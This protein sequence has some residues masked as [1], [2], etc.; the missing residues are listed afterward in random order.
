MCQRG[1]WKETKMLTFIA[2]SIKYTGV[3]F[4]KTEAGCLKI[5]SQYLYLTNRER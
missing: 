4:I 2:Y 3:G 1:K 5:I